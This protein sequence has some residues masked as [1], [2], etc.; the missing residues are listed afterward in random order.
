MWQLQPC[1]AI[2]C[3]I[4]VSDRG[5]PYGA[6]AAMKPWERPSR[7]GNLPVMMAPLDG[8]HTSCVYIA[9][10]LTPALASASRCGV[11]AS[12]PGRYPMSANPK[13]YI[14]ACTAQE[15][16]RP[17]GRSSATDAAGPRT[18]ASRNTTCGAA[19][20]RRSAG[21]SSAGRGPECAAANGAVDAARA[22]SD[23]ITS[24]AAASAGTSAERRALQ[25]ELSVSR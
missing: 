17:G 22:S 25:R 16:V 3:A 12:V 23:C 6:P 21:L 14:C 1:A 5:S 18:S 13:S 8:L 19:G 15:A 11:R 7:Y 10:S 9:S 2:S 24:A 4:V 20:C